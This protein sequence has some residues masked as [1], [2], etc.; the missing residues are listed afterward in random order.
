MSGY[1][2]L[3]S[4]LENLLALGDVRIGGDRP[5]DIT[6]N[7]ER[8]YRSALAGGSVGLG[9][10]Y[11]EGWWD[12]AQLDEM[13]H[14]MLTADGVQRLLQ[15][16][17]A[18]AIAYVRATFVNLQ[19]KTRSVRNVHEHYDI[20][21]D[22][23]R[24]MLDGRMVYSC[25]DWENAE[26]LDEAQEAKLD[27]VCRK[28]GLA[29]GD[30]VLDIGCGWGSFAK[31]AAE[32]YGAAVVG[33]TLSKEQAELARRR[34]ARLP[35][36]IRV[37]DYRDLREKFDHVISLGM[38]EHVGYKNYRH[39]MEVVQG[40]L[41]P[42]GRFFLECIGSNRS[43]HATDPWIDK[44]IFPGSM[45]PSIKQIGKAIEGLMITEELQNWGPYYDK[46]LML[47][48]QNFHAH[49]NQ[50][51]KSYGD[52][53]YRMWKYY[54]LISAGLFRSRAIQDWEILLTPCN[55]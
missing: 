46:T 21:N 35:V 10:S 44:Y 3:K 36:E 42:G 30:V 27:F 6:V 5:W 39:Y 11:V 37:Q 7:N 22:L 23:Y 18:N 55:L 47:W 15:S 54:L 31:F 20:G 13:I 26:S 34:C 2:N 17:W 40:C 53:F 48:Y 14:R 4:R 12:C 9:E 28:V 29:A 32:K 8:F 24:M 43:E 41:R 52:R 33:I 51:Q 38:F 16:M 25:G 49:W 19:S 45:L 50:M 1:N